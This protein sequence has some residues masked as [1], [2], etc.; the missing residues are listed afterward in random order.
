MGKVLAFDV[1]TPNS[2]N[3]RI[4][5]IGLSLIDDGS[6]VWS[7]NYLVNPECSFDNRNIQIHGIHPQD[8][9]T[10]PTFPLVWNEIGSLFRQN[11]V[12]AHN[13]TFDLC[14]LKKTLSAY[15]ISEALVYYACTMQMAQSELPD[16]PNLKLPTLCDYYDIELNHHDSGSD[17]SACAQIFCHM[18]DE[19]IRPEDF[20]KAY[21]LECTQA[22]PSHSRPVHMAANTKGLLTLSGILS[23]ITCDNVLVP[24]EVDF[25]QNWLDDNVEL[26]GNYPYDKIYSTIAAALSDGILDRAEL[27]SMLRLFKH[28]S[29]PVNDCSCNCS[30]TD[31]SGKNFCLSGEFDYGE[32]SAVEALLVQRGGIPQKGVTRKTDFLIVGGQGSSAWCAGNYGTKVKKALEL[33]EKGFSI[34]IIREHDFL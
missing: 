21:S 31:I 5:S 1:E 22:T 7:Q 33:Q 6:I 4:C 13:A 16:L 27:E 25:L 10:A 34:Q 32:K 14:V 23:G 17:S 15:G 2:H 8:I 30:P 28:V 19:G 26:K 24:S 3:D 12:I 9:A 20:T 29:D 18:L 11:L